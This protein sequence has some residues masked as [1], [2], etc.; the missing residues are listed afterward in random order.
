MSLPV[1]GAPTRV[2]VLA[3][4]GGTN[5]QALI[6]AH[7]GGALGP[8]RLVVVGSNVAGCGALDRART[9]GLD[10]FVIEHQ[11]H[12]TREAFDRAV[13]A[14]LRAR[15]IELVVLAGFMRIVTAELLD[16]F[17]AR[18]INIH[19][20][21]LPAFPGVHSQQQ[22]FD[23]GVKVTGCTVHFVELG[24]DSGPIIAQAVVPV[25]PDDDAERLRL[26]I[27]AEEHKLLPAVVRA[28]AEGRVTV[29]GRRVRVTP[30]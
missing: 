7:V 24:V 9:A 16:A 2:G 26:R 12:P 5:L 22:A 1:S 18:I 28:I 3:S 19:P 15:Q 20:S 14:E 30:V 21:L 6:D 25:L 4:G 17:P 29:D 13:V 27:L 11:G 10:T 23:Y 8:A